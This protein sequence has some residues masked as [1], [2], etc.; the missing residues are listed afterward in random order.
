MTILRN[1][2]R[3]SMTSMSKQHI[4]LARHLLGL[5]IAKNQLVSLPVD[6]SSARFYSSVPQGYK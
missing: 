3:F 5:R 1:A 4:G 2:L 6:K